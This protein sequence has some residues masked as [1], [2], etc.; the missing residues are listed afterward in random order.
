MYRNTVKGIWPLKGII[1]Y[2]LYR[3]ILWYLLLET[4]LVDDHVCWC[5]CMYYSHAF[6][7]G[8]PE[9][10]RFPICDMTHMIWTIFYGPYS[11][12]HTV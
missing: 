8:S 7:I 5:S 1:W 3:I 12:N 10:V 11:M 2:K 4:G 9:M 6:K